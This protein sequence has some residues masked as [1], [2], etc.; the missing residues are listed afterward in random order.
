MSL[1]RLLEVFK[2]WRLQVEEAAINR[3]AHLI[4][5]SVI[6]DDRR[7]S[8]VARGSPYWLKEV[9]DNESVLPSN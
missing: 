1:V 7:H 4:A 9:L 5:H 2:D 3:G 6:Q 8:Y